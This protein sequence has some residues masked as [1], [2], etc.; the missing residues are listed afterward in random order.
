MS[1]AGCMSNSSGDKAK[2]KYKSW[3]DK[4]RKEV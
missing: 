3:H 2:T 4:G 1:F